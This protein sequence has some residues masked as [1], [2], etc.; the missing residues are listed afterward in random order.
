MR[1]AR[2]TTRQC[3]TNVWKLRLDAAIKIRLAN[4]TKGRLL[5]YM[6]HR[7]VKEF[8]QIRVEID[9]WPVALGIAAGSISPSRHI[10]HARF[11]WRMESY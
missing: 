6:D 10:V 3:W 7:T 1:A 9:V 8:N 11:N 4:L 2:W 5:A